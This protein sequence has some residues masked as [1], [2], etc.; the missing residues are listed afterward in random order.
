MSNDANKISVII[1]TKDRYDDIK[2]L[3]SDLATQ[4]LL[5]NE[6]II[7]DATEM[8]QSLGDYS[9]R[10]SPIVH[11]HSLPGL[12]RQ[13]NVGVENAHGD[14]LFFFDDDVRLE[15]NYLAEVMAVFL[16]DNHKKIGGVMGKIVM[17]NEWYNRQKLIIK[18]KHNLV[19]L[20][21]IL[22][23]HN[24]N[25]NGKFRL[26]G[27]PTHPGE[28]NQSRFIECLSGGLTAY[29]RQVFEKIKFDENLKKYGYMEDSD[30]SKQ[31]KDAGY[32]AYY[33]A[34][35][36]LRHMKS[37]GNRLKRYALLKMMVIYYYYL[38]NKH[39]A[40]D[41]Y[42]WIFFYWAILG[43]FV[44]YGNKQQERQGILDGIRTILKFKKAE[45]VLQEII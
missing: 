34:T 33:C 23:Q 3:L 22:F 38:F 35:A 20:N 42:R 32:L 9:N 27:F 19:L 13:R 29:R 1:C 4:T 10:L 24:Y 36:R 15:N 37:G 5:A 7:V 30:S 44:L 39:W 6:I 12:T 40:K 25:G 26:S 45:R 18:I 31:L 21:K 43:F 11:I 17:E 14:F 16:Q 41:F 2:N 28:L 8:P